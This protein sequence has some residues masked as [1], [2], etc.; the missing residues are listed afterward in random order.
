MDISVAMPYLKI[1]SG[2]HLNLV[3]QSH[4]QF[5]NSYNI[6]K[7]KIMNSKYLFTIVNVCEIGHYHDLF[8]T[9]MFTE[10]LMSLYVTTIILRE[11][12]TI[13]FL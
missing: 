1:A 10:V 7:Q 11:N 13:M 3:F 8:F 6:I 5:N 2:T 4:R 9:K 12:A